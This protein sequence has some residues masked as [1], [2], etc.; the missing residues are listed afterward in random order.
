MD[1][2]RDRAQR[3]NDLLRVIAS[4]GQKHFNYQKSGYGFCSLEI[5]KQG[6]VFF[7]DTYSGRRIYT[8]YPGQWRGFTNGGT[9]QSLIIAMREYICGDRESLGRHLGP[10]PDS[11]CGGDLWC[12]GS[13]MELVRLSAISL[14]LLPK[15]GGE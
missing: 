1:E 6:H 14:G 4:C 13:D 8:H 15:E 11:S 12:Y 5:G 10:W 3:C 7:W 9:L 2:K